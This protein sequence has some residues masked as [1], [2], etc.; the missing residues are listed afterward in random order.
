M[1][2]MNGSLASIL[3]SAALGIRRKLSGYKF[4][5]REYWR[6][7]YALGGT[8]GAGSYNHLAAFKADILNRF[9]EGHSIRSLIEFGC[10]D[11]NQLSLAVYPDYAGYDIITEAIEICR[12]TFRGDASKQ[13]YLMDNYDGRQ[14]EMSLSLDVVFHLIEDEVFERYMGQLFDAATRF[15]AVYSSNTDE[16]SA[17]TTLHV[18]HRK[19]TRWVDTKR[20]EWRLIE[21]VDNK[22]SYDGDH[23]RTSFADFYFYERR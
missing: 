3:R 2:A 12:E 22:Y 18:K 13:F 6:E 7:R 16:N 20:S 1:G 14:A 15:V 5:S 9:V 23:T 19:F 17:N 4:S 10:G 11:G 8:S 21:V